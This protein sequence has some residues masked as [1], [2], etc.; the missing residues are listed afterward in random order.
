MPSAKDIR[1]FR[2]F[3]RQATDRQVKWIYDVSVRYGK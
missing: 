1:E 2:G 3:L